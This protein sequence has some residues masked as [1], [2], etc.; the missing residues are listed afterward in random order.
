MTSLRMSGVLISMSLGMSC[1]VFHTIFGCESVQNRI[2]LFGN[3][4][5]LLIAK[6]DYK[7][8]EILISD[9]ND[10]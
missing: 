2:E 4:C 9:T 1:E 3:I 10:W 8:I 6:K 7:F 5:E